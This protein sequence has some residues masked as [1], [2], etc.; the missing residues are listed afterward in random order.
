MHRIRTLATLL[1]A[2]VVAALPAA[3]AAGAAS[4]PAWPVRPIRLVAPYATGGGTDIVARLFARHLAD[5][6]GQQVVVDN[7]PG[8]GGVLG[9]EIAARSVPDGYTLMMA[10]S[11]LTVL[12]SLHRKLPYDAV[13]DFDPVSQ[14]VSYPL[15][16]V[17]HPSVPAKSVKELLALARSAPKPLVYASGGN[18]SAAHLAAELFRSMTGVRLV[19]VPYKGA[20]PALIGI[21]G[22]EANLAF[23]SVSA[24]LAHVKGGRLH[25]LGTTGEKR[26]PALPELP[27]LSEAGVPGYEASTWAGMLLPAGAPRA[28]IDRLHA[29]LMN[30]LR[31]PEVRDRLVGMEFE[32]VG[33]TPEQF[34]EIIGR[35]VVKW[36]AVVK[37]SG[38]RVD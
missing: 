24:T 5:A 19:H 37:A 8:A 6:F 21:T 10:S 33:N 12:P 14:L 25:A 28:V 16:L 17:V 2:A 32:I 7:R 26:S 9:A 22:G 35:E 15:L 30:A 36:A 34:R 13:K 27:T 20:G 23:Y 11:T 4:G 38:A 3:P 29:E 1:A 31:A 18:G